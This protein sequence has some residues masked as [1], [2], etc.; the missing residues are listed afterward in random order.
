MTHK[1]KRLARN[2]YADANGISIFVKGSERGNRFPLGTPLSELIKARDDREEVAAWRSADVSASTC[3]R[4]RGELSQLYTALNGK[5]GYNP[6]RAVPKFNPV[7][8]DPRGF[9]LAVMDSIID[10]M[11]DRGRPDK[12]TSLEEGTL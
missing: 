3:D 10:S 12:G 11:P 2:I 9:D 6:V 8:D 7:Y 5:V 4:R 1:R